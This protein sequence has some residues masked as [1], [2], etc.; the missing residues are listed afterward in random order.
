MSIGDQIT[1]PIDWMDEAEVVGGHRLSK[2]TSLT[3][4]VIYIHPKLRY[5]TLEF[6][7]PHGSFR[8]CFEVSG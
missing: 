4:T 2:Q 5:Y 6:K 1:K 3:G 8:E 7:L